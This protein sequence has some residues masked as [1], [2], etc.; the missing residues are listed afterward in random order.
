M[1]VIKFPNP[2]DRKKRNL[3]L[4]SFAIFHNGHLKLLEKAKEKKEKFAILIIQNPSSIPNNSKK[5]IESL[6]IRLQKISNLNVEEAIVLE[7]DSK[8]QFTSGKEFAKTLKKKYFINEFIVG[9]DFKMGK[10][11]NYDAKQLQKDFKTTIVKNYYYEKNKIST[12]LLR[13]FVEFGEVDLIKKLSP[14]YFSINVNVNYKNEF[15]INN[16]KPKF[17]NY[18]GWII[19]NDLKYWCIIYINKDKNKLYIPEL[20]IKNKSFSGTLEFIKKIRF[21]NNNFKDKITKEDIEYSIKFLSI[22]N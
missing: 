15:K 1:K 22:A 12:Q 4:G 13:E 20:L 6:E 10:N 3:I 8:I 21:F 7:F 5:E 2:L 17:G 18:V 9:Q 11:R 16:L 14:F 19:V